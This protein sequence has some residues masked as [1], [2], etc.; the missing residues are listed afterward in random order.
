MIRFAPEAL[1]EAQKIIREK[2]T[3]F[4]LATLFFPKDLR[5]ATHILYAYLRISDDIADKQGATLT[6][7]LNWKDALHKGDESFVSKAAILRAAAELFRERDMPAQY[8]DD[9]FRAL[10][11]DIKKE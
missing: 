2:S 3:S 10:E 8:L 7:L 9:F 11:S 4:F 6:E 5:D 1:G